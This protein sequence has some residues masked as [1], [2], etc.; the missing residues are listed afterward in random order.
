MD[1]AYK[2]TPRTARL[3]PEDVID[4]PDINTVIYEKE[5]FEPKDGES[6]G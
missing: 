4:R 5:K 1:E 2:D 6:N 3:L